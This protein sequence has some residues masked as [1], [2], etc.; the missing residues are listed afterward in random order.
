MGAADTAKNILDKYKR[1]K[2]TPQADT[3]IFPNEDFIYVM[4]WKEKEKKK[5]HN[6]FE[7]IFMS[8]KRK[9]K[10]WENKYFNQRNIPL[11]IKCILVVHFI[12]GSPQHMK[13]NGQILILYLFPI[14]TTF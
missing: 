11:K 10:S 4:K 3:L 14:I 8:T 6:Y 13:Y 9:K 7:N 5:K 12:W 1:L 2:I